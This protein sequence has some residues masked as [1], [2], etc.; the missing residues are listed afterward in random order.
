M[1]LAAIVA[2]AFPLAAAP[3]HLTLEATPAAPFPFLSKF[4]TVTLH[5]YNGGVRA[6][7][8]W[9]N[10]FSRDASPNITVENP[11]GRM[12]TEV[13]VANVGT[14]VGKLAGAE[15]RN[16]TPQ[17]ATPTAGRVGELP[18]MRYRLIFGPAAYIDI[19]S[20]HV[21]PENTQLRAIVM[22][23]VSGVSP[24]TASLAKTIPGTPIYVELNF[25]RFQKLPLLRLKSIAY[26]NSG[27][28]DALKVS[29]FMLHASLLDNLW[30]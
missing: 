2:I 5:V 18:A 26:D 11:Y 27:E 19:W 20:T 15:L 14:I 12:Y 17:L 29:S 24:G 23:F 13:P 28:A 25:R 6:E 9:L 30:K 8:F 10:G 22:Q 1:F 4:G 3:Y 7:T 21:F 16:A